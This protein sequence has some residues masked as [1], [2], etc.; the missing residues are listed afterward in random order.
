MWAVYMGGASGETDKN[1]FLDMVM[2]K[3]VLLY[4]NSLSR[5]SVT[6]VWF[7]LSVFLYNKK[8]KKNRRRRA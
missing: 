2:V 5:A 4:M 7:S 6:S 8:H 3:K 1:L